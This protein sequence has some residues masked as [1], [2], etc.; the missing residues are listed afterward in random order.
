[1]SGVRKLESYKE[2]DTGMFGASIGVMGAAELV[3]VHAEG[4]NDPLDS[5]C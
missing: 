3:R 4:A 5:G 2:S 1:M